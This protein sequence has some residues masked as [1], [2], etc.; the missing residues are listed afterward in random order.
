MWHQRSCGRREFRGVSNFEERAKE[1][2]DASKRRWT[3]GAPRPRSRRH[4]CACSV[5][6]GRQSGPSRRIP[7]CVGATTSERTER[8]QDKEHRQDKGPV[9]GNCHA[10]LPAT[11]ILRPQLQRGQPPC[12]GDFLRATG[13]TNWTR[14]AAL[15]ATMRQ[16]SYF[17]SYTHPSR[18]KGSATRVG[19]I[20]AML[21][22]PGDITTDCR[23]VVNGRLFQ[24]D[25]L[26]RERRQ[27]V[28]VAR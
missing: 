18:W 25:L 19:C 27:V 7:H 22:R 16:P 17:S 6:P 1:W 26:N 3:P 15:Y 9:D 24:R 28:R 4:I 10:Q 13:L 23:V 11:P 12:Q 2:P 8:G 14:W 5:P 20:T 21:G